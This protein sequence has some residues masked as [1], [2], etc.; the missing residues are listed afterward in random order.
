VRRFIV[1]TFLWAVLAGVPALVVAGSQ[2]RQRCIRE[3]RSDCSVLLWRAGR[4]YCATHVC[5]PQIRVKPIRIRPIK[6]IRVKPLVVS[7]S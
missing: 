4:D 6:P 7:G 3:E 5:V 1:V 2:H